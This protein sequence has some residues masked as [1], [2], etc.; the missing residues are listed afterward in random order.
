MRSSKSQKDLGSGFCT[1]IH[2]FYIYITV[3]RSF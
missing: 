1:R 3:S 2:A